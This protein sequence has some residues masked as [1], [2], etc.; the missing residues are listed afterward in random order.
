M[1]SQF[2]T[3]FNELMGTL[4]STAPTYIRCIK[5]N[6][7]KRAFKLDALECL[8][9]LKYA[10]MIETV[11]I[12]QQGYAMRQVHMHAHVLFKDDPLDS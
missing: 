7:E 10:G 11:R 2:K 1:S 4:S 5:S 6:H 3:Q 9:Q 12:R 8:R